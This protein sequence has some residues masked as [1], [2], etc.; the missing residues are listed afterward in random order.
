MRDFGFED[1]GNYQISALTMIF[2]LIWTTGRMI[3]VDVFPY[4]GICTG[5][6]IYKRFN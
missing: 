4:I 2:K 5:S 1:E 3:L 6:Y